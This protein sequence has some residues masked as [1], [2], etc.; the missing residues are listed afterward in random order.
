MPSQSTRTLLHGTFR[1]TQSPAHRDS[2]PAGWST[3]PQVPGTTMCRSSSRRLAGHAPYT[4]FTCSQPSRLQ[5]PSASYQERPFPFKFSLFQIFLK[6]SPLQCLQNLSK[7]TQNKCSVWVPAGSVLCE[8]LGSKRG[9]FFHPEPFPRK[10]QGGQS[11]M[12][13][14]WARPAPRGGR[15]SGVA[16]GDRG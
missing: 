12:V 6:L 2:I 10:P 16:E 9:A 3:H 8:T 14:G 13:V 1:G 4:D 7:T 5:R 11:G 15:P